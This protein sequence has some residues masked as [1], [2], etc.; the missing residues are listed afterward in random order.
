MR[1]VCAQRERLAK[2]TLPFH[3]ERANL[4]PAKALKLA[5]ASDL[6]NFGFEHEF[7]GRLPIRVACDSLSKKDL[8]EILT[9]SEHSIID[10]YKTSFSY[11]GIKLKFKKKALKLL[12]E[13]AYEQ[14]TGARGLVAV[15]ETLLRP[16][17]F[18][19]P[20]LDIKELEINEDVVR[21]PMGTLH[22]L[23]DQ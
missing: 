20:S 2:I 13:Q 16:F 12:A 6:V 3:N 22:H 10:Q 4:E 17:K 14:K 19:L 9:Q 7:I 21:N 15:F 11:Y 1:R 8:Y 23:M 5:E 18:E